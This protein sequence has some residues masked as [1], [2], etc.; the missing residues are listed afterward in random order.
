MRRRSRSQLASDRDPGCGGRGHV[1]QQLRDRPAGGRQQRGRACGV[2]A[3]AVE[4]RERELQ[5]AQD[6]GLPP[7]AQLRP[8]DGAPVGAAGLP[9]SAGLCDPH[10]VRSG[11]GRMAQGSHDAW[12]AHAL[13][14]EPAGPDQLSGVLLLDRAAGHP[15]L[16]QAA[17]KPI[18]LSR[19]P[20][21]SHPEPNRITAA[22]NPKR[23]TAA[24]EDPGLLSI[25]AQGT[26]PGGRCPECGY[27]SRAVHSRYRRPPADLPALGRAVRLALRLRRFYCRNAACPRR[28]FAEHLPE[29]ISPHA[30]RTG[31]L[32]E[33]QARVGAALGG[34][35]S[36]RLLQHLA[37]PASA[38]TVLRLIRNLPLPEPEPPRVVGVDD[39]A[40]RKGHTY[41][42]IVVDL[43]RRRVL[44]LLPDRTAETLADWLRGQPQIAVVARDRSTEYARGIGLGAPGATQVADRWRVT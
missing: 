30:R 25:T 22:Q 4:D 20:E 3:G 17:P 27:A 44:D 23:R 7:G 11:R 12:A 32:A 41:G 37:M 21:P 43:D 14:P 5:R 24:R 9:Q 28:T 16:R 15:G 39:W 10:R 36:A 33:A 19:P 35:G 18:G 2:R 8:R 38:D 42:T 6:R 40:L 13:L 1:P 26:R 29:L 34:E 31:R